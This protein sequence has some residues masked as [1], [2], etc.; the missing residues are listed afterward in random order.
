MKYDFETLLSRKNQ[1]S[2]KWQE[3]YD[4]NPNLGEDIVPLSVADMELKTAPEI[5]EGL[6]S[7]LD[8]AILGY[9]MAYPSFI[10]AIQNWCKRH[11]NYEVKEEWIINTPGIVNALYAAVNAFTKEG[12]GVLIFRPVYY[13]FTKA[14]EDN[15]RTLVNCPLIEKDG[16]YSI[17]FNK[18]DSITQEKNVKLVIFCNPHN[19]VGRV[20]TKEELTKIAEIC[21]KNNVILV[22]D[23]IHCDLI[24]PG[25]EF[26]S[27]LNVESD[28]KNNL[29]V[30]TAPSKT[31]NLAGL[32]TSNIF[33]PNKELKEKYYAALALMKNTMINIL[34]YK[35]C[36]LAYNNCDEWLKELILV[37]DHN[38]KI[39]KKFFDE[40]FPMIKAPLIQGTYLM[41][42][43]FR[44][45]SLSNEEL[46]KF[47]Q[48]EAQWF[49]DE[50][51]IFGIE[52]NGYERINL[53]APTHVIENA[54]IRLEKALNKFFNK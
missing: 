30:C 7:F 13:P 32:C 47:M 20:W 54:L 34:G 50:G 5:T 15:K 22:S 26:V 17:D 24:M 25:Y 44:A 11:Y 40:K 21:L 37:L 12:D 4:I 52:G 41:W 31:F 53:A 39:V 46:E 35:A 9:T 33:V 18:F 28:I 27:M 29:I 45:L 16:E 8:E 36:E 6:K 49:T 10:E 1:G 2:I 38:Q 43:D 23:E 42:I 14:I 48:E 3:M 51:Y 19:P